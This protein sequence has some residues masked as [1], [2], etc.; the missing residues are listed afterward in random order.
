MTIILSRE[1]GGPVLSSCSPSANLQNLSVFWKG[2]LYVSGTVAFLSG[3]LIFVAA[4]L[5]ITLDHLALVAKGLTF[6]VP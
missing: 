4:S 3:V 6:L 1:L 5:G 2:D